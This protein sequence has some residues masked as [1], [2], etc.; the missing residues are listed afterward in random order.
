MNEKKPAGYWTYERCLAE[1]QKYKFK[2][3]FRNASAG[4]YDAAKDKGWISEYTWLESRSLTKWTYETCYEE[5]KKYK[6]RSAFGKEASSA[7][8]TARKNGWL[9]DYVWF[10]SD[11]KP[12]GYW[13]Y[14]TCY[15]E[16]K[17]YKKRGDFAVASGV[18]YRFA[19]KNGWIDD[20]TWFKSGTTPAGY[21]TY[22]RCWHEAKKY[23]TRND[24]HKANLGA[25]DAAYR[26]RWLEDYVWF[27]SKFVWTYD[28]CYEVAKQY[29]TKR[30]FE[31]GNCGAY[32]AARRKGWLK[33]YTWMVS[34]RVNVITGNPDNVYSYY[35]EEYNAIYI[36]RTIHP[37]KRDRE[38]LFNMQND[39][40]ARFAYEHNCPVPPMYII[41]DGL[42]LEKGQERED[43]WVNYYKKQGYIVLNSA[44]TGVGI[45]SLGAIGAGK[46]NRERCFNEAKKYSYRKEFQRG[47]VG[48]YTR[49]LQM[50]WLEDY[51]WFKRPQ[52]WNQKWDKDSCYDEALKYRTTSDF[53]NGSKQAYITA[54]DNSWFEDYVWLV[55]TRRKTAKRMTFDMCLEEAIKYKERKDFQKDS[56]RACKAAIKNGWIDQFTW[57]SGEFKKYPSSKKRWN[58]ESCYEEAKKYKSRSEFQYG[59]GSSHAY[60]VAREN[61]WIKDYF[62]FEEKQKPN[63]YWTYERCY[64]EAKKFK[65]RTDF[66][67]AKG[68]SRAYKV[69]RANGW[70]EDYTWFEEFS[71]PA[72]YWTYERCLEE[73][74][75]YISRNDFRKG[76]QSAYTISNRN[77][78]MKD[79]VWLKAPKYWTYEECKEIAKKYS[80]RSAFKNGDRRAYS[81]SVA[82]KWMNDFFPPAKK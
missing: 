53:K 82:H 59:K 66:L 2:I 38:H 44:K 24:F 49:A 18:A 26:N 58:Y 41:E 77:G 71:K 34:N 60:R 76:N 69:A 31:K 74:K 79:F 78:W 54:R 73:S 1:A 55:D 14:E 50:G 48:A 39:I 57:L 65:T 67:N 27:E 20:Y 9:D 13:T 17:K 23:K 63:G 11:R 35:F 61:D 56:P 21:W 15:E 25:Y 72:G 37:R 29:K 28:A 80:T 64:E 46:W 4:A 47:S 42:S 75:K 45:G 68:L 12:A 62:W 16:A 19:R 81:A 8:N 32:T 36:G 40:V 30:E 33:D 6:T 43:Y 51:T 22:D 3:D 5:A 10:V 70:L 52:N 7:Y